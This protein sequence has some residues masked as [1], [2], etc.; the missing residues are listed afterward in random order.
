MQKFFNALSNNTFGILIRYFG[1]INDGR[2]SYNL[3]A[4]FSE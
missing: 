2:A 1:G 4:I 3:Q